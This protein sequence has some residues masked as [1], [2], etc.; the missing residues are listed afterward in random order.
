MS[1]RL[2]LESRDKNFAKKLQISLD[3]GKIGV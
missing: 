1:T 2:R 3:R